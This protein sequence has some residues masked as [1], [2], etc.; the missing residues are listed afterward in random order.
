M[1]NSEQLSLA[2]VI[3]LTGRWSRKILRDRLCGSPRASRVMGSLNNNEQVL[4]IDLVAGLDQH[5]GD[6]AVALG[7][8]RRFHLHRLDGK[9]HVAG[10]HRL[11]GGNG[12]RRDNARHRRTDMCLIARLRLAP[13][14]RWVLR[15]AGGVLPPAPS[16][17][18]PSAFLRGHGADR[19]LCLGAVS[20]DAIACQ[21]GRGGSSRHGSLRRPLHHRA[22]ARI[23]PYVRTA[24]LK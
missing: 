13:R 9:Q 19:E 5:L 18:V 20:V 17:A 8:Q 12:E 16:L 21:P 7:M 10:L 23:C 6:C 3:L 4:G 22:V 15:E 24:S 1:G 2:E 14:S 11:A